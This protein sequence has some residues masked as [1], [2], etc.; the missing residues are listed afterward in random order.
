MADKVIGLRWLPSTTCAKSRYLN[1]P[2]AKPVQR[3]KWNWRRNIDYYLERHALKL[4]EPPYERHIAVVWKSWDYP[5]LDFRKSS[6][7]DL[8]IVHQAFLLLFNLFKTTSA[9][10]LAV[11][12]VQLRQ[13]YPQPQTVF[14]AG[15]ISSIHN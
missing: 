5:L 3:K 1:A 8:G 7:I 11:C 2:Y 12:M 15:Y 10:L 4:V 6:G 14:W 9:S 13:F